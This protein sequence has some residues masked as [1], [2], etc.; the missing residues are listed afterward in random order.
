MKTE[1]K[2]WTSRDP[3]KWRLIAHNDQGA[4]LEFW[5]RTKKGCLAQFDMEYSRKGWIIKFDHYIN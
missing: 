2:Y 3:R 5:D 1:K 4:S